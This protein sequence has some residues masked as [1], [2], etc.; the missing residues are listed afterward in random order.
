MH[1]AY[2]PVVQETCPFTC[3]ACEDRRLADGREPTADELDWIE[4]MSVPQADELDQIDE[5]T[6]VV[7]PTTAPAAGVQQKTEEFSDSDAK[8][9]YPWLLE[10]EQRSSPYSS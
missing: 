8:F 10:A 5:L 3:D 4:E 1:P 7:S 6:V 2:A 9:F